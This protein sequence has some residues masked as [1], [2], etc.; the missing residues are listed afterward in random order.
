MPP[1]SVSEHLL[2][3]SPDRLVM[4]RR[5]PETGRQLVVKVFVTGSLAEAEREAAMA[6][7]AAGPGVVPHLGAGLDPATNRPCVQSEFTEGLDL[8]AISAERGALPAA[9]ACR[10]L[11][12][13]AATL[14]RLH[15][16]RCEAAPAGLCHGDIKPA[17]LLST[18]ATTLLLD[19]EHAQPIAVRAVEPVALGTVGFRAPEA[20]P[21]GVPGPA[22]DVFA[23]GRTLAFLLAGG[24]P[25]R[26]P[27]H[28]RIERLLAAALHRD[29]A[30]RP[31]AAALAE[32]LREL[33]DLLAAD[34]AEAR[35]H[36]ALAGAFGMAAPD[37]G[38]DCAA[39]R[40]WRRRRR[41]LQRRPELLSI[42]D[43]A[44]TGPRLLLE[45]LQ[46]TQRALVQFP[47]HPGLLRRRR[48]LQQAATRLLAQASA[49]AAALCKAEAFAAV[50]DWLQTSMAAIQAAAALP[51]GLPL[52][53]DEDV[54]AVRARHQDPAAFL[55][56][57]GQQVQD[58]EA[59]LLRETERIAAAERRLDL[60][61]AEE[62]IAALAA[63]Y[64]G[65]SPTVARQRDRLHRLAF[66]LERVAR[67]ATNVERVAPLW[68]AAA[69]LPLQQFVAAA[70]EACSRDRRT[71]GGQAAV[72]LRSLQLT[73]ANLAEENTHVEAAT[74]ALEA[75]SLLLQHVTDQAWQLLA[76]ARARLATVPVPVRPLQL[77]LSRLDAFRVLEAFVDRPE[78]PRS[79]LLDG[80]ESLRLQL[81]QARATRDRLAAS[82]EHALA[83]GHW[84]TGLFDMERAVAGMNTAD[85][86][87]AA[88]AERLQQRLEQARRRRQEVEAAVR[89]NVELATSYGT[90][91][92]D[93][94]ST[95][96]QRLQV[97][98]DRRDCLLFLSMHVPA[99]RAA[100]YGR[101][102]REVDT[103]IVLERA[104]LAE[105]QLDGTVD[106]AARLA[107]ARETCARLDEFVG[108][109]G[110]GEDRP[111]R[112]VRV[113]E[114]WRTVAEHCRRAV[115]E[116]QAAAAQRARQRRRLVALAIA[117][118][119]VTT[120][121][122]ALA[123]RPWL[124][125]EPVRAGSR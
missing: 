59:D 95:F 119:V 42:A 43:D 116:L 123:V 75:L 44:P 66:Y 54:L 88:E 33:A 5:D 115:D 98:E 19:F 99:E 69:L 36:D 63:R 80:I 101:D 111:G 32:E 6:A 16:L 46:R 82:A 31:T 21:R 13:V 38:D 110:H 112:V 18:A 37:D 122:V 51:G 108:N 1:V 12:P 73:L 60:P 15:G 65:A 90:L 25:R 47:R 30:Q 34:A 20:E 9:E 76:E 27:Q 39:A 79:Q 11:A 125:G 91:Q 23:F 50:T 94:T 85:E 124:Q 107:L 55:R 64:G 45:A 41:L 102:L 56:R 24:A 113:L 84:T 48:E 26:L 58:A 53:A 114:H 49:Q 103:Q 67:A 117:A 93:P 87:D 121:A 92:D 35:C 83:R 86:R 52:P 28:P 22:I 17:N 2:H 120:T 71:E 7:A 89:R 81:E 8:A 10:L 72:G 118:F 106:P 97:L 96:G 3:C 57:I 100:L 74:P 61:A 4:V 62:A 104:G 109:G 29:P 105:H 68:D 14:A 40:I 70:A 78:R 77:T